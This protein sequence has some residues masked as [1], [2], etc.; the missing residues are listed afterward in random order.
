MAIGCVLY[1]YVPVFYFI[2]GR[3]TATTWQGEL[4]RGICKQ[5]ERTNCNP[6][7]SGF[8][9]FQ[10]LPMMIYIIITQVH[11]GWVDAALESAIRN[12][13]HNFFFLFPFIR[14]PVTFSYWILPKVPPKFP[15][16]VHSQT[17]TW[18]KCGLPLMRRSLERVRFLDQFFSEAFYSLQRFMELFQN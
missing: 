7:R 13:S 17:G 9:C 1:L 3:V 4:C 11:N 12:H 16:F 10:T 5:G 18:S 8:K 2:P 15:K 6:S 14:L